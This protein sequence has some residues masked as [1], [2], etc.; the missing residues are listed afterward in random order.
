MPEIFSN[1]F[2]CYY[3]GAEPWTF[4]SAT[5]ENHLHS[6][7]VI[8]DGK[9]LCFSLLQIWIPV[10]GFISISWCDACMLIEIIHGQMQMDLIKE[11]LRV[12][13]IH[14]LIIVFRR[15]YSLEHF[16]SDLLIIELWW[17]LSIHIESR[18]NNIHRSQYGLF[19]I[20]NWLSNLQVNWL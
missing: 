14:L 15:W 3:S 19:S 20:R 6:I 9:W 10:P 12:I 16:N 8:N 17:R 4:F 11:K 5:N 13:I 18:N 1:A 7:T 2:Q